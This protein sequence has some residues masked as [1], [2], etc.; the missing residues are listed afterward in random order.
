LKGLAD[1]SGELRCVEIR[2]IFTLL[3]LL[4]DRFQLSGDLRFLIFDGLGRVVARII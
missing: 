2:V 1:Q 3:R 4:E